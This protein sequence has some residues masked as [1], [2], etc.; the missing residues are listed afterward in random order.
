[1]FIR[2]IAGLFLLLTVPL[3]SEATAVELTDV[4]K[5]LETPFNSETTESGRI[6]SFQAEFFQESHIASIKRVQHGQGTVSFKFAERSV[7]GAMQAMFRWEYR[8]PSVQEIISDGRTLWVYL[9][10]NRQVIESDIS[11]VSAQQGE[12]PVTFL[13]NLGN[14]SRDFSISWGAEQVDKEGNYLLRLDPRKESQLIQQMQVVVSGAA[15]TDWRTGHRTAEVFPLLSTLV[16]DP[17]GNR[18][19]IEFHDVKINRKL[20]DRLFSFEKPEDVDL[21]KPDE[22]M[23]F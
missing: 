11:Q 12:N 19:L 22:Q 17:T 6:K 21:L 9:P 18:T 1:M 4:I 23:A 14:L 16:T 13:S 7:S 20:E 8:E 15:V 3:A 2:L 5:S 10:E